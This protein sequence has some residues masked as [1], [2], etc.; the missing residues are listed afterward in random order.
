[1]R[2]LHRREEE[3]RTIEEE[4]R[5]ERRVADEVVQSMSTAKQEKYLAMATANE[6][7]LQVWQ[8]SDP[9]AVILPSCFYSLNVITV[10]V[11]HYVIICDAQSSS[12]S[13]S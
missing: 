8:K 4:I 9:N 2:L 12:L 7:L 3:I 1:M 6:D 5:K 11:S 10:F 13:S